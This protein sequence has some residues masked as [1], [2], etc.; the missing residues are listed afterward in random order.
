MRIAPQPPPHAAQ[1]LG[2]AERPL[3]GGEEVQQHAQRKQVAAR[4]VAHAEQPLGRHVGRGAVGQPEFF[5]QQI[6]QLVVMRQPE[7][8]QHGFAGG[9]KHDAARLD[10]V[11]DD[12]LRVQVGQRGRD[13]ADDD[14]RLFVGNRQLAQALVKRLAGNALDH[15]IGLPREIAGPEAGRHVRPRQPRQDHLLHLE[16][17]DGGRILAF[18]NP[19]HLHQHRRVAVGPG[20]APQR[21]H[22][23][24]MD[25]L[26]DREAV[27]DGA[28][29]N[30]VLTIAHLPTRSRSASQSGRPLS[31]IRC[32]AASTS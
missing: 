5:L 22:A 6:R 19:R 11:M 9:A 29:L 4:I 30:Q 20:H 17:D 10:V 18:G 24:A 3:A 23:A 8:D 27:D 32:A 14:P 31:R 2:L 16:T 7:I 28:R 26:P 25:A 1:G 21:R 15:D 13:L 12:V